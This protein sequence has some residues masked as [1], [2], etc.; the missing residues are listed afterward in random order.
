MH[1]GSVRPP[2]T[3][4]ISRPVL[5]EVSAHGSAS[6]RNCPLASTIC[7]AP[8][9]EA[10]KWG[11]LREKRRASISAILGPTPSGAGESGETRA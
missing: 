9:F 4:I 2:R 10:E 1:L 3:A 5:V 11:L 6:D 8:R 7:L